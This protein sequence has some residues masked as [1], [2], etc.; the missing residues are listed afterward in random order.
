MALQQACPDADQLIGINGMINYETDR[1]AEGVYQA[2]RQR[3]GT[4]HQLVNG[5]WERQLAAEQSRQLLQALSGQPADLGG[6]GLDGAG[7]T[8]HTRAYG[9]RTILRRRF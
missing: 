8:G 9:G 4:V 5:K 2:M 1:R 3:G 6:V 7:G